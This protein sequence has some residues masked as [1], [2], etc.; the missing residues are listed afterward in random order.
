MVVFFALALQRKDLTT[1]NT[2]MSES[3][4]QRSREE[5]INL[6]WSEEDLLSNG[7]PLPSTDTPSHLTCDVDDNNNPVLTR[8]TFVDEPSCIGCKQCALIARCTFFMEDSQGKA[9]VYHQAGDSQDVIEEAID[10]CPVDCIYSV[11]Y[12]TLVSLEERRG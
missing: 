6:I 2:L 1:V 8:F 7:Q 11:S 3:R 9:R 12:D 10:T 4:N 5:M